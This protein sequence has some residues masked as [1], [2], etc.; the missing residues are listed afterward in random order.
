MKTTPL[1][2]EVPKTHI[3]FELGRSSVPAACKIG[4]AEVPSCKKVQRGLESSSET[5]MSAGQ[6][7]V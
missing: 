5:G 2:L 3:T 6:T 7:R 4:G 1:L